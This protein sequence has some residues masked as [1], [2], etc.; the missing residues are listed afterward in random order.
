MLSLKKKASK[1][2]YGTAGDNHNYDLED[3]Y[4]KK[5]SKKD[6]TTKG[7]YD[8][9][10][11]NDSEDNSLNSDDK[12]FKLGEFIF[13]FKNLRI[14]R[15]KRN[16]TIINQRASLH[17]EDSTLTSLSENE[18]NFDKFTSNV[19]IAKNEEERQ[20][21]YKRAL[22]VQTVIPMKKKV[23]KLTRERRESRK[24]ALTV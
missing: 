15:T 22:T 21:N 7:H 17:S 1:L 13:D 4:S 12:C 20:E 24:R 19:D 2:E 14:Q 11:N 18:V 3:Y 8:A 5:G 9:S 6:K 10:F 16:T 23:K